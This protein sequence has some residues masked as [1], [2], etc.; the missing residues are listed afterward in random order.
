MAQLV[1]MLATKDEDLSS[2]PRTHR[3]E[4]RTDY[5]K[6]HS[7]SS[8]VHGARAYTHTNKKFFKSFLKRK[9]KSSNLNLK[10]VF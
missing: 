10:S 7:D 6:L 5:Y 9:V 2:I 3:V 8:C 1:K 4:K